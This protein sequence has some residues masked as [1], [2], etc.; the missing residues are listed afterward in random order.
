MCN[1]KTVLGKILLF[2][3]NS[4]IIALKV[5]SH[6]MR[7]SKP[8]ALSI[9]RF[10][11]LYC[12]E[13]T[14]LS[15]SCVTTAIKHKRRFIDCVNDFDKRIVFT[16]QSHNINGIML[17]FIANSIALLSP[18]IVFHL[19]LFIQLCHKFMP[20]F[21]KNIIVCSIQCVIVLYSRLFIQ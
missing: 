2:A 1:W 10:S 8:L 19:H 3:M 17:N 21:I 14:S 18:Y 4:S 9:N 20:H 13:Y 15:H 16:S 6:T 11:L 12:G 7:S 5:C